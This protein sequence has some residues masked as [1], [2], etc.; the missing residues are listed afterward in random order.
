MKIVMVSIIIPNYNKAA[1]ISETLDSLINQTYSDWEAIIIDDGSID[2]STE[3]IELYTQKESRFRFIKRNRLP[4]GGSTCR[5]IGLENAKGDT[6]IF[7]DSDDI[8]IPSCLENRVNQLNKRNKNH[9]LVFSGG[10]FYKNP[11]DSASK[12]IPPLRNHLQKFLLH[13]LPWHTTSVIWKKDFLKLLKGFDE[14]FPRLQDVELHTRALLFPDIQYRIIGGEP[15]FY[16]RIDED[17]KLKS[18]FL[19]VESFIS[20][21]HLYTSNMTNIINANKPHQKTKLIKVL[22]GT[23]QAAYLTAQTQYDFGNITK[24]ERN[25][26]FL[27]IENFHHPKGLFKLYVQGLTIGIHKIKGYNWLSKKTLTRVCP[28]SQVFEL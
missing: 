17:R 26:L 15:D 5:N 11:G 18:P 21:V 13:T 9:F 1:Y 6:I 20:G 24:A 12:W 22:N 25:K 10:T 4:K 16:Y 14:A 27:E 23:Y 7:L 3:I 2:N 28:E 8:L 19:F